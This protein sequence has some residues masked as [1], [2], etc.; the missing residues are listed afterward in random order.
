[1]HARFL[2]PSIMKFGTRKCI[3]WS[4]RSA[5]RE[6]EQPR[7]YLHD[8]WVQLSFQISISPL[9]NYIPT[10]LLIGLVTGAPE[11][12]CARSGLQVP[13]KIT[14]IFIFLRLLVTFSVSTFTLSLGYLLCYPF[15]VF[16]KCSPS[17][18]TKLLLYPCRGP[19]FHLLM[20][21]NSKDVRLS[22]SILELAPWQTSQQAA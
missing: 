3:S 19:T 10:G 22:P 13:R 16:I 12:D 6:G 4:L 9:L 20:G 1:M 17:F 5:F 8:S 11:L 7:F 15:P 2:G 21:L 14:N 18:L